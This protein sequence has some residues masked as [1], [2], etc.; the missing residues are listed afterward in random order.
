[1]TNDALALIVLY[2]NIAGQIK[3][4]QEKHPDWF[5]DSQTFVGQDTDGDFFITVTSKDARAAFFVALDESCGHV[6]FRENKDPVNFSLPL[7][8]S[9]I[10][11]ILFWIGPGM[12]ER[13]I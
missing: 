13:F 11:S 10:E 9:E 5:V 6:V 12:T 3:A 2:G 8:D 7:T 4:V 1:M